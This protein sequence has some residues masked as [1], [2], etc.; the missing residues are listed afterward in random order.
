MRIKVRDLPYSRVDV[1][2]VED[3]VN[4]FVEAEKTATSAEEVLKAREEMFDAFEE[5]NT[6]S[7]IAS[8][9]YTLNTRDD[10]YVAEQEYYDEVYPIIGDLY[11]TYAKVMLNSRFRPELEKLVPETVYPCLVYSE[12]AHSPEVI[13]DE[14]EENAIITKYTQLL[15]QLTTE[16]RGEQ[17]TIA[18][19]RG[20]FEDK[21]REVRKQAAEAVDRALAT[22][23]DELDNIYD[24]LVKVRTRIARKLGYDNFVEL[25]SYRMSRID[26]DKDM[27]AKFRENVLKSIVPVVTEMKKGIAKSLGIEKMRFYDIDV[28]EGD[29]NPR[30]YPDEQ[31]ILKSAQEMYN[32][33]HPEIG[34][35]MKSMLEAEAFDVTARDGKC[36]GGYCTSFDK[37]KQEFIFANFNGSAGDVDVTT[38]EFGHAIA[39][40]YTYDNGDPDVGIGSMETAETHSMSMEFFAWKFM[41]KFFKDAERYKYSHL[42][43][44]LTFI[45]YGIIVDEFQ[46]IVYG[47]PDMTPAERNQAYLDLEKKYRPYMD[48][49]GLPYLSK[50]TRWQFQSNIYE[51]PFYYIDY[52]IAQ[53]IALEFL[54]ELTKD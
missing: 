15:S 16:W 2:L 28:I 50:G 17:K 37:F 8:A 49:E 31:G 24:Q 38:H 35:F 36:G 52:C 39:M 10:F 19:I 11:N 12:K 22:V 1:K 4:K 13:A 46:H 33:M 41:D 34:D 26:Y 9:R 42:A 29:G 3:A 44:C 25:G 27:V 51:A 53:V 23:G 18:Y 54:D 20:F 14:Q 7:S 48:Y 43:S 45:P 47:N 21:D 40:H 32:E 6:N 5:F 30:P